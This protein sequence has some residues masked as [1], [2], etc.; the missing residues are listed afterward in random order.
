MPLHILLVDDDDDLRTSL[1][2]FLR[3]R[4][5]TVRA[6]R[7][8]KEALVDL[9]AFRPQLVISDIQM[10]GM[11]GIELLRRIRAH[12]EDLPVILMTVE[13][14]VDTA[15]EALRNRAYDYLEKPIDLR[16]LASC[17]EKVERSSTG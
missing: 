13:R 6:L 10:P 17:V 9:D 14:T 2:A 15:T 7:T 8:G 1:E 5:H 16:T 4:K 3:V 11:D 12:D